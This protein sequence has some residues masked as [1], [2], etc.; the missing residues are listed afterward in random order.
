MQIAFQKRADKT[1][2]SRGNIWT[3]HLGTRS[4]GKCLFFPGQNLSVRSRRRYNNM[5]RSTYFWKT[6]TRY[7]LKICRLEYIEDLKRP[8]LAFS[9]FQRSELDT[10][11]AADRRNCSACARAV[12]HS[13]VVVRI[14][15]SDL[16]AMRTRFSIRAAVSRWIAL[17]DLVA[18]TTIATPGTCINMKM[19]DIVIMNAVMCAILLC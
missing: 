4:F 17:V 8:Y 12:M 9:S 19:V 13:V 6:M 1:F 18:G 16:P 15:V 5:S 2:G 7:V 11:L 14:Q 3:T 10:S